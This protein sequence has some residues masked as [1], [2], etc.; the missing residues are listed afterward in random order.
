MPEPLYAR[1]LAIREKKLGAEHLDVAVSLNNLGALYDAQ[2]QF[3]KAEPFYRRALEIRQKLL[4]PES[5][6]LAQSFS[7]LGELYLATHNNEKAEPLLQ[8]AY[9]IRQAALS[10]KNP[11]RV[12]AKHDLWAVYMSRGRLC[13]RG[14]VR[15][16]GILMSE[17]HSERGQRSTFDS[18]ATAGSTQTK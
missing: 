13:A 10:D 5:L 15:G 14:A 12:A 17:E 8:K 9:A 1:S 18:D 6:D 3:D 2:D 11:D 4:P 7:N 16:G